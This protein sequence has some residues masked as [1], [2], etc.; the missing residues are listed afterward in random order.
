[1]EFLF[2]DSISAFEEG[3]E[4]IAVTFASG[5]QRSFSL[6][7]GCD[8]TH[9]AVRRMYFGEESSFL[10]FLQHYFSLTIVDKLLIEENTTQRFNVPGKT[11]MLSSY[12]K[13]TD[14]AFCFFSEK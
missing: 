12:N 14:I 3:E 10:V 7:F 5:T 8:G 9:S 6:L 4:E 2:D 11:V 1:M 13:K